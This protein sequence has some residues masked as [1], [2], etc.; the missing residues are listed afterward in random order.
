MTWYLFGVGF[1][2]YVR[3]LSKDPISPL[4]FVSLPVILVYVLSYIYTQNATQSVYAEGYNMAATSI[5]VGMMLI[6]QLNG[7]NYLLNYLNHDLIRPMKWRLKAAPYHT[8]TLVF[9]GA[10]ACILLTIFQGLL[11]VAFS[12][13]FLDVYWGN[14]WVTILVVLLISVISQLLGMIL[15]LF[16][17]RVGTANGLLWIIAWAMAIFGGLMFRLPDNT[18]FRFMQQYGTPFSLGQTAIRQSGFLAM[19]PGDVPVCIAALTGIAAVMAAVIVVLGRR[20]L[21]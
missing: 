12:A 14:L 8:H 15:L 13:L 17:R 20:R 5:A 1:R 16:V 10:A 2:H 19:S 4:I 21:T 18:F 3:R 7:G 6:F 9:S 11:V